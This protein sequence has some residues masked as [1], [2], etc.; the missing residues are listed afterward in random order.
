MHRGRCQQPGHR[1]PGRAAPPLQSEGAGARAQAGPRRLGEGS[2]TLSSTKSQSRGRRR[3]PPRVLAG[4]CPIAAW[5]GTRGNGGAGWLPRRFTM[6]NGGCSLRPWAP[7][8]LPAGACCLCSPP[9]PA[10]FRFL[11]PGS[12]RNVPGAAVL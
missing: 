5:T 7:R 11:L 4:R 8:L 2:P 1:D 9:A 6:A 3:R 12:S 10:P